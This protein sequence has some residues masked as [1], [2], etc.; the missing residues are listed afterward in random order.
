MRS[1]PWPNETLRTVNDAR[2]PPRWMPI[3][4]P[5]KIWMRSL[6]P[7]RTFTWTFTVSPARIAGRWASCGCS[8]RS[9][10]PMSKLL[11]D[12]SFF[13][14]Q[15]RVR[16]QFRP[17]FERAAQRLALTPPPDLGMIPRQQHVRYAN[18]LV[19]QR[20]HF[21]RARELREIEQPARER[22]LRHRLLVA[23]HARH[24]P[25]DRVEHDERRQFAAG[26]HV[27]TD[28]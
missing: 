19:A 17:P 16:Q 9:I 23:D 15:F 12:V 5:S 11:Q 14:V 21:S 26:Q 18:G 25:R 10:A 22:I 20:P 27:V 4:T 3:T 13:F 6:S 2:V 24:E 7:S 28:R 1:T 8:M